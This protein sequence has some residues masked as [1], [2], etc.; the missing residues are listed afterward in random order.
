MLRTIGWISQGKNSEALPDELI[1]S[2]LKFQA[3]DRCMKIRA[4]TVGLMQ[5]TVCWALR[6]RVVNMCFQAPE[7]WVGLNIQVQTQ[8]IV[9][10]TEGW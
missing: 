9:I 4:N 1:T 10:C 2:F 7:L 3:R 6:S 8:D 5:H